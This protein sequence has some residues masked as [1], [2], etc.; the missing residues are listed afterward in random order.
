MHRWAGSLTLAVL[1][2]LIPHGTKCCLAS[3][4]V[5]PAILAGVP[6]DFIDL[7]TK[8][9]VDIGAA[10]E[11]ALGTAQYVNRTKHILSVGTEGLEEDHPRLTGR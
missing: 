10:R 1:Q 9:N 8:L 2:Q 11:Y 6:P 7:A 5:G 4:D 3:T